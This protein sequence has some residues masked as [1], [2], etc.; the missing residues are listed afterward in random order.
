M[1]VYTSNGETSISQQMLVSL[2][3]NFTMQSRTYRIAA[4]SLRLCKDV[5]ENFYIDC[6]NKAYKNKILFSDL[7][8]CV[9]TP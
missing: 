9:T 8:S 7:N 5:R 6:N 2:G 3:A 4:E 1:S